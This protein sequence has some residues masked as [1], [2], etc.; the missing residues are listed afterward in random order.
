M[1]GDCRIRPAHSADLPRLARL[2]EECFPDPWSED[3]FRELLAATGGLVLVA[4]DNRGEVVGYLAVRRVLDESEILNLAV[5]PPL[6]RRGIGRALLE[7]ALEELRLH[8]ISQVYLEVRESNLAAQR[9]YGGLGFRPIGQRPNYY[10]SPRE[11]GL[12]LCLTLQGTA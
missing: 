7:G 6:R 4:E 1:A 3:G 5:A 10:R 12:V 8:A 2:E 11:N 9:L